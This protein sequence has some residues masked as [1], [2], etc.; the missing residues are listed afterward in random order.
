MRNKLGQF[1]KGV[2]PWNKGKKDFRPSPN[3]EFKAGEHHTGENHPSW[4][5]GEQLNTKDCI[6]VWDG[7]NKRVRRPR[8]VY[9]EHHG[10]IP[11]GYVVIHL[12]GNKHNDDPANLKAI[13]RA[14][15]L[16]RN[17]RE[18]GRV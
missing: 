7:T 12:D 9:E 11:K 4:K 5:G 17:V 8:K 15:N 1:I 10:P 16:K 2:I 14:E 18:N 6:H 13:S 3:T